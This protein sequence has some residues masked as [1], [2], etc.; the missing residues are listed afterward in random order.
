DSIWLEAAQLFLRAPRPKSNF[1]FRGSCSSMQR[2]SLGSARRGVRRYLGP[3]AWHRDSVG[4]KFYAARAEHPARCSG[5]RTD[6][7]A[8]H[9]DE[10]GLLRN[11]R[12]FQKLHGRGDEIGFPQGGDAMSSRPQPRQYGSR[13]SVQGTERSLSSLVGVA[14]T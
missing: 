7:N 11:S 9:D 4:N 3:A 1:H 5:W 6:W 2:G 8:K 10:T 14:E 13:N 12:R